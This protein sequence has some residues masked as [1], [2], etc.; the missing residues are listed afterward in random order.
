[1]TDDI[2]NFTRDFSENITVNASYQVVNFTDGTW[3]QNKLLKMSSGTSASVAI[4]PV[5]TSR[6]FLY[7]SY[8]SNYYGMSYSTNYV[9]FASPTSVSMT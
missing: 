3:V 1:M 7:H 2:I 5:D 4:E 6:A 8:S 9:M